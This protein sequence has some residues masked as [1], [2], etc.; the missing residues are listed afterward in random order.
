M[1]SL[2]HFLTAIAL[3]MPG[4]PGGAPRDVDQAASV[5]AVDEWQAAVDP[6]G[7]PLLPR[8]VTDGPLGEMRDVL[9]NDTWDQV[10]IEQRLIIR[11]APP[12]GAGREIA[13][14]PP[15][16]PVRL[17]ERKM[18]KCVSLAGIAGVQPTSDSRLL[19]FLRDRRMVGA[20]LDKACSPRDFYMGFYIQQT[21]DGMLCAGRD[22][23][24]SR[25][26]ST[27]TVSRLRELVP[28]E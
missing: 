14:A 12:R 21:Q 5:P 1:T 20:S 19:L 11:V 7:P 26:G 24:H 2:A 23:I 9:A 17:R 3:A 18:S 15:I 10:R 27:C 4:L 28:G 25:S 16:D 8:A 13:Q 6:D 22:S